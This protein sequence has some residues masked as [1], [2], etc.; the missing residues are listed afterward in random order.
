MK[1]N[2]QEGAEMEV[3]A[4]KGMCVNVQMDFMDLTVKKV[5]RKFPQYFFLN[6]SDTKAVTAWYSPQSE[7]PLSHVARYLNILNSKTYVNYH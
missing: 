5:T 7:C 3:F 1:L 4:M 2:A 6:S